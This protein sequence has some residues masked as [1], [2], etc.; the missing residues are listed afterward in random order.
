[1]DS[2]TSGPLS[3]GILGVEIGRAMSGFATRG[4]AMVCVIE[5]C[6]AKVCPQSRFVHCRFAPRTSGVSSRDVRTRAGALQCGHAIDRREGPAFRSAGVRPI[7]DDIPLPPQNDDLQSSPEP[8]ELHRSR[9]HF[10][11]S[12]RSF[13]P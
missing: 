12:T 1:M 11:E 10:A 5:S 13:R 2:G 8:L 7:P 4:G 6:A 9:L 3:R